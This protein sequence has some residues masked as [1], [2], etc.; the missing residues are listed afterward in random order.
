MPDGLMVHHACSCP[1][2]LE[3]FV[4]LELQ[5]VVICLTQVLGMTPGS[6][7]KAVNALNH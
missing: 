4:E 1:R 2:K 3:V 7:A 6:S 5:A